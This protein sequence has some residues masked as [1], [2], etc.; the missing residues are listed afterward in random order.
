VTADPIPL[1]GVDADRRAVLLEIVRVVLGPHADKA[2]VTV[3][4]YAADIA[5]C[6]RATAY[7][8]VRRGDVASM[9]IAGR[10]VIPVPAIAAQLLGFQA[11][12]ENATKAADS[13]PATSVLTGHHGRT[14]GVR[15]PE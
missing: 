4:E 2:T 15:D 5:H 8:G 13:T 3:D 10:I 11:N 12:S 7:E 6:A 14:R 1:A 9:R